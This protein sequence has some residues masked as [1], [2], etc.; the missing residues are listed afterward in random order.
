[1]DSNYVFLCGVMWCGYGQQE[2]GKELLRAT[3]SLDPDIRALACAMLAKGLNELRK[4]VLGRP[5][6]E[7]FEDSRLRKT[8]PVIDKLPSPARA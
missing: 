2:A 7:H 6:E 3:S 5:G 1:M 4:K 8:I